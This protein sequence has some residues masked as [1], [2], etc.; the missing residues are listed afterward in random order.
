MAGAY[1]VVVA[2]NCHHTQRLHANALRLKGRLA[3]LVAKDDIGVDVGIEVRNA[4]RLDGVLE[5]SLALTRLVVGAFAGLVV[6]AVTVDIHVT[7]RLG[8][9]EVD[10]AMILV[11][12]AVGETSYIRS[13]PN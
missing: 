10:E 4:I 1:Q 9:G 11:V 6:G 8:A 5:G 7:E 3:V 2:H 13:Q 12:S